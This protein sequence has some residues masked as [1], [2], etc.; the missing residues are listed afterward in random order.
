MAIN[1]ITDL[2]SLYSD[3]EELLLFAFSSPS[4]S[5]EPL[6]RQV[7]DTVLSL[8]DFSTKCWEVIAT[9]FRI[10]SS[11]IQIAL[12]AYNGKNA[13]QELNRMSSQANLQLSPAESERMAKIF[14]DRQL[15]IISSLCSFLHIPNLLNEHP[16]VNKWSAL[17]GL[18]TRVISLIRSANPAH[19]HT[20][21]SPARQ[22]FQVLTD[23]ICTVASAVFFALQMG[24]ISKEDLIAKYTM[25]LGT[26]CSSMQVTLTTRDFLLYLHSQIDIVDLSPHA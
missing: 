17:H 14:L 25:L 12:G 6:A 15:V 23:S 4:E 5:F 22:N 7:T 3:T 2:N 8:P 11:F 19:T 10:G 26:A 1:T 9:P 16:G 20:P 24:Y 13:Y 18:A 21:L